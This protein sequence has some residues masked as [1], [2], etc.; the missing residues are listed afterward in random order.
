MI[1]LT[2]DGSADVR[3]AACEFLGKAEAND[4]EEAIR[5]CLDDDAWVVRRSAVEALE[6]ISGGKYMPEITA[7]L[8]DSNEA[9]RDSVKKYAAKHIKSALGDIENFL[10][11]GN[12]LVQKDSVE[13]LEVSGYDKQMLDDMLSESAEARKKATDIL[14]AMI[15]AGARF[16]MECDLKGYSDD[17][18]N[19]I[20]NIVSSLD[21]NLAEEIKERLKSKTLRK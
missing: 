15:K 20:L 16:G 2:A 1:R 9:V 14:S 4:A 18:C 7:L 12:R 8:K 17:K 21:N 13:I 5:K 6:R 11:S 19:K 10:K 3:S